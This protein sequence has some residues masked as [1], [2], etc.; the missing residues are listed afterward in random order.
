MQ[1]PASFAH[2]F[3]LKNAADDHQPTRI[4]LGY[5]H[6]Q[7]F[8]SLTISAPSKHPTKNQ[9]ILNKKSKFKELI[10]IKIRN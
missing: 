9:L 1:P 6:Y 8:S 5:Y 7:Q 3:Q 10:T 4:S 2:N